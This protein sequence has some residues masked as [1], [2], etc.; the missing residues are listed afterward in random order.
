MTSNLDATG[1]TRTHGAYTLVDAT[2]VILGR[3]IAHVQDDEQVLVPFTKRNAVFVVN[4][5]D[6]RQVVVA[7]EETGLDGTRIS[8]LR[9]DDASL[10]SDRDATPS[11]QIISANSEG[12]TVRA[13]V[14]GAALGGVIGAAVLGVLLLVIA[15][16]TAALWGLFGGLAL[17]A[18]LGALWTAFNRM[19]A[20]DAWERSLHVDPEAFASIAV[21]SDDDDGLRRVGHVLE[22]RPVWVFAGD[23]VVLRH[24]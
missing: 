14:V 21:H 4:G 15:S 9:L 17:G 20:S 7:L 10:S 16:R 12:R 11:S 3:S 18:A 22:G 23:G 19:G 5:D 1:R 6:A 24:P 8:F 2:A 13:V